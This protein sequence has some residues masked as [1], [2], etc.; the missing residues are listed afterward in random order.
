MFV[1]FWAITSEIFV[2]FLLIRHI[3]IVPPS[4]SGGRGGKGLTMIRGKPLFF[5]NFVLSE[6]LSGVPSLLTILSETPK[7]CESNKI[8]ICF[9]INEKITV[10]DLGIYR[11][12][13]FLHV[14]IKL[15]QHYH[16]LLQD[17]MTTVSSTNNELIII[18][19]I[20]IYFLF[21]ILHLN[22]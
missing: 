20:L 15:H 21:H 16:H 13:K 7:R 3:E 22:S 8:Y 19:K 11:N 6:R 2:S 10:N 9:F 5:L 17:D 14:F 12:W 1:T 4:A 18:T